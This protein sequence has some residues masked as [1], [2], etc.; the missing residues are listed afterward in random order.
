MIF[1]KA[2]SC[3]K[4]NETFRSLSGKK[5]LEQVFCPLC[6][7]NAVENSLLVN[8]SGV[9]GR[10]G[11]WG[12]KFNDDVLFG[13]N[14][15]NKLTDDVLIDVFDSQKCIFDFIPQRTPRMFYRIEGVKK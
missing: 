4:T 1:T 8:I 14:K 2:C 7:E 13:K 3:Q 10:S 12:L 6:V 9:P 11:L 15:K 5:I